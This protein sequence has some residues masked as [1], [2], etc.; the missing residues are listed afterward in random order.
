MK[1]TITIRVIVLIGFIGIILIE[2]VDSY[3]FNAKFPVGMEMLSVSALLMSWVL[4][5]YFL[6]FCMYCM[7]GGSC[8]PLLMYVCGDQRK[9]MGGGSFTL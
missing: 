9:I 1:K 3:L 5:I 2:W 8:V 4:I 7:S 6:H